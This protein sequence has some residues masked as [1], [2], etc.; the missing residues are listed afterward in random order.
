MNRNLTIALWTCLA[1]APALVGWV[2]CASDDGRAPAIG[3]E[4]CNHPGCQQS[5]A[6]IAQDTGA[7]TT[8][9]TDVDL[10]DG[11]RGTVT[12]K[13]WWAKGPTFNPQSGDHPFLAQPATV[14]CFF[15]KVD[16][17]AVYEPDGGF[18]LTDLPFAEFGFW[19]EDIDDKNGLLSTYWPFGVK[20]ASVN[21]EVAVIARQEVVDI[22]ASVSPPLTIDSTKALVLMT[23]VSQ[24]GGGVGALVIN[25]PKPAE[26]VLYYV[27]DKWQRD[28]T[29]G[30][31]GDGMAMIV[32][33]DANPYPGDS[34]VFT[35]HKPPTAKGKTEGFVPVAQGAI[36]I[37]YQWESWTE[38]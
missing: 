22:L 32:N 23:I 28:L 11:P 10:Y 6:G 36:S 4:Q 20:Q 18:V 30:T 29:T 33:M 13:L 12:G 9:V 37:V 14:R 26:A 31:G 24:G 16:Y 21:A 1:L 17:T 3:L 38:Y 19:A 25:P 7:D 8:T 5:D 15:N 27:D 34:M 2:A 35:Y